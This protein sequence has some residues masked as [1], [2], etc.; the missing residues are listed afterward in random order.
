MRNETNVKA[1]AFLEAILMPMPNLQAFPV[2]MR[3]MFQAFRSPD[4]GWDL[5]VN[6][7]AFIE[8]VLP[9]AILQEV[10]G[11]R[12]EQISRAVS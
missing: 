1:I 12:D 7:N 10:D 6:Q 8:R 2:E 4:V 9:G 3:E 5:I 11:G